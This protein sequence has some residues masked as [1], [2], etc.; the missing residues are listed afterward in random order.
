MS[1]FTSIFGGQSF[2]DAPVNGETWGR[3]DAAWARVVAVD[4][5]TMTG[6]LVLPGDPIA[7][8]QAATKNYVDTRI[9]GT[10]QYIGRINAATGICDYT[11]ASGFPDGPVVPAASAP[12]GYLICTVAGTIPSGPA[13]GVVMAVG[14]W[15]LS[16]GVAWNDVAV[17]LVNIL[18]SQVEVD[19][20]VASASD[21]QVALQNLQAQKAG[22][23][24]VGIGNGVGRQR[25][26][27]YNGPI[28]MKGVVIKVF[29]NA[30][31]GVDFELYSNTGS[32]SAGGTSTNGWFLTLYGRMVTGP[33]GS[34]LGGVSLH[35][36]AANQGVVCVQSDG[37]SAGMNFY[38]ELL[39]GSFLSTGGGV[40]SGTEL[41]YLTNDM[42][43]AKGA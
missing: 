38:Y 15:L 14:D 2:A 22:F 8:Q 4:G 5:D 6:P 35:L 32:P 42:T 17:G 21:V 11:A 24:S 26:F 41:A 18:A 12:N 20:P 36:N 25:V 29:S 1:G 7:P 30:N 9:T 27:T 43:I 37:S 19:P 3:R 33:G 23:G 16:D 31:Y 13:V 10:A 39:R 34:P 40:E 28:W